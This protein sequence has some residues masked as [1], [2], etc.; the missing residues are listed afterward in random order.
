MALTDNLVSYWKLDESSGNAA[1]SVGSNTLTNVGSVGYASAKI[2]NGAN[3]NSL[4]TKELSIVD[5]SQTGLDFSTA[6]SISCWIKPADFTSAHQIVTKYDF[7][8]DNRSYSL[9]SSASG[10]LV[11]S[12]SDD[13]TFNSGHGQIYTTSGASLSESAFTHIILT[14]EMNSGSPIVIFYKNSS[15]VSNSKTAGTTIGNSIFNGTA[16]FS[17]GQRYN[18]GSLDNNGLNGYIDEVGVWNRVL[19]STEVSSLYNSGNGLQYPFSTTSIKSFN[20]LAIA[21]VKSVNGLAKASVKSIN[22]LV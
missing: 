4:T 3:I 5:A 16:P 1:D 15:S 8:N 11:L 13:G 7:G 14:V 17:L 22:G 6:F 19:T 18:N 10:E 2:N 9:A 21:S 12:I 20:G